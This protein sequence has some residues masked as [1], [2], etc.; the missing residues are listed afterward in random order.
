MKYHQHID[1][2][3]EWVRLKSLTGFRLRC[4]S[5]GSVHVLGFR[6]RR[7]GGKTVLEF[8][9]RGDARA[10]AYARRNRVYPLIKQKRVC[11]GK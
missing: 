1:G 3:G 6:V 10:T 11:G 9:A 8:S 7:I 5:C 2:E 4:C